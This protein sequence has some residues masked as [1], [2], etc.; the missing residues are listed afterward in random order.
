M[1]PLGVIDIVF[2][3]IPLEK[4]AYNSFNHVIKKENC[5]VLTICS[6]K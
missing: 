5:S 4:K 6:S 1:N 2:D 3:K